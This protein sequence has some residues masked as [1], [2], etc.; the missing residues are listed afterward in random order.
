[1]TEQLHLSNDSELSLWEVSISLLLLESLGI[2]LLLGESSS[3]GSGKLGSELLG[4]S[5]VGVCGV[6]LL[7][8]FL[9]A[10]LVLKH[11]S[12]VTSLFLVEHGQGS[13]DALSDDLRI[14]GVPLRPTRGIVGRRRRLPSIKLRNSN[15]HRSWRAWRRRRLRPG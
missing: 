6:V 5:L 15:L 12:D 10:V 11:G 4:E 14:R 3:H 8:E 1:M 2:E 9:E 13:G 7:V